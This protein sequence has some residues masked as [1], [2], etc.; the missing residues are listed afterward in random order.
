MLP[1]NTLTSHIDCGIMA[2]ANSSLF[3]TRPAGEYKPFIPVADIRKRLAPN[4][5][6]LIAIGGWGDTAGFSK[7]A[8]NADSRDEYARNV[9]DMLYKHGFDGVD[10]DWEYPGGNGED[11]KINPNEKKRGEIETFPQLLASIR[12]AIRD[13]ILSIAVPGR[14]VDMIAYTKQQAPKIWQSVDFVNV[15][16]YD[17]MNRR[18]NVTKHH[19]DFEGSLKTV[20]KYICLGLQ[21]SKINLGFAFYAKWFTTAPGANCTATPVGCKVVPMERVEGSDNGNSGAVTFEKANMVPPPAN[22]T[23]SM[24]G[25]CGYAFGKKCSKGMCCS[26]FGNW[27]VMPTFPPS[28]NRKLT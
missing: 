8:A 3:T 14:E 20:N 17:L 21:P 13:K 7:G 22:L 6:V 9:A 25:E 1:N 4:A 2:F 15:M 27:C 11:Y 26:Q 10:I 19:S 23:E 12:R 24:D 16:T 18:E 28:A 5:T